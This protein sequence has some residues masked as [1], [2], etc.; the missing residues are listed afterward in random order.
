MQTTIIQHLISP[1]YP[2]LMQNNTVPNRRQPAT[3]PALVKVICL[4]WGAVLWIATPLYAQNYDWEATPQLHPIDEAFANEPAVMI[5]DRRLVA[6]A[7]NDKNELGVYNIQHRIVRVNN[8]KGV[9]MYNKIYVPLSY[10]AELEEIKARVITPGGKVINLP[11][12]KILDAEEEG[13][14]YKKFA[15]E[16]VE[17]GS[18]VEY[19]VRQQKPLGFFGL[20]V[21]Q[22][23]STPVQQAVLVLSVP[24]HLKFTVKGYQ[25][26]E[27]SPDTVMDGQRV[28]YVIGKNLPALEPEKY[29]E[30]GPYAANAQYKLSYNLDKDPKARLFSWNQLAENV[31][32][33]YEPTLPEKKA[34]A[35]FVKTLNLPK[36]GG[37]EAV[38]IALEDYLKTNI[39]VNEEAIGE[40]ADQIEAMIKNRIASQSGFT[41]LFGLCLQELGIAYHIVFPSKRNE[42]PLDEELENYR[43]LDESLF[44]FPAT[45]QFL[46][47]LNLGMRYPYV[48]PYWAAT[49]GVFLIP[50]TAGGKPEARF[51]QIPMQ[52]YD[53]SMH[54]I[55]ARLRF[56]KTLDSVYLQAKQIFG[57][58]SAS[59]YRPAFHFLPQD[60]QEEFTRDLL[61]SVGKTK[62]IRSVKTQNIKMTDGA[63]NKPLIIAGDMVSADLLEQAGNKI[64]LKIGDVIGPQEEMYQEKDRKLPLTIQYPHV[65]DRLIE[66]ELPL[67]YTIKNPNDLVINITGKET[68][69]DNMGFISNYKLEGRKLTITIH[70]YYKDADYPLSRLDNFTRIINAAADF[71]KVVLV[72]EKK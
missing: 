1:C 56:N 62:E 28:T 34:I 43:L 31:W 14:Q 2:L 40:E 8:Q 19:I 54:N 39:S 65:L 64:L 6:Y 26:M 48:Q 12:D 58:Y 53:L 11:A 61:Q 57:G 10:D 42:I 63:A 50:A 18:E 9:E 47:P 38:V 20:E 70:E 25:G 36:A 60:R 41:R 71:N 49:K 67:G 32:S 44:Y 15:L 3:S 24:E 55:E 27:A 69:E 30:T 37:A 29:A 35:S 7:G 5:T 59:L 66:V 33:G 51:S 72:L 46:E 13:R 17:K 68:G 22:N 45:K 52:R 23:T 21:F 4:I 16:G